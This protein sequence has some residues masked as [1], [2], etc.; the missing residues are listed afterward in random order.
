ME[1]SIADVLMGVMEGMALLGIGKVGGVSFFGSFSFQCIHFLFVVWKISRFHAFL[2][3][4]VENSKYTYHLTAFLFHPGR[5]FNCSTASDANRKVPHSNFGMHISI[6]SLSLFA[7]SFLPSP[8]PIPPFTPPSL[9]S[10]PRFPLQL[11]D[12]PPP[13][14]AL[15]PPPRR[16]CKF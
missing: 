1:I 14:P 11:S 15:A 7:P 3:H 4:L 9:L 5:S 12:S 2:A 6:P 10:P 13:R 8:S 16:K